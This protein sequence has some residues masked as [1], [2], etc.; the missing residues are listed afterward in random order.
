MPLQFLS[1]LSIITRTLL[2]LIRFVV[3]A[4][5][6]CAAI[7]EIDLGVFLVS[8]ANFWMGIQNVVLWQCYLKFCVINMHWGVFYESSVGDIEFETNWLYVEWK[9]S[10]HCGSN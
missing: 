8:H 7:C 1:P 4:F 3:D 5:F 2:P 10:Y 6:F 9:F